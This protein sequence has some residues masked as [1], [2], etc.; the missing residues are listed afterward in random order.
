MLEDVSISKISTLADA[1]RYNR[2]IMHSSNTPEIRLG[3]YEKID[4]I[5]YNKLANTDYCVKNIIGDVSR[6]LL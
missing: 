5:G 4:N 2:N 1:Y 3:I 6:V